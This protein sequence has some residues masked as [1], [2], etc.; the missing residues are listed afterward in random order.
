MKTVFSTAIVLWGFSCL[1]QSFASAQDTESLNR[2]WAEDSCW[3]GIIKQRSTNGRESS[4]DGELLVTKR[5]GNTFEGRWTVLD[6]RGEMEIKGTVKGTKVAF[7][8]T[9]IL[10]WD[11]PNPNNART[12]ENLLGVSASGQI[13][14]KAKTKEAVLDLSYTFPAAHDATVV[15]RGVGT[16][17]LDE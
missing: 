16:L 9:K 6:G 5:E 7:S 8:I 15:R 3:K 10:K 2:K 12:P 17:V 1:G 14:R 11:D 13:R 4:F